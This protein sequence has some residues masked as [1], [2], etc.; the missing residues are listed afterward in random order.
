MIGAHFVKSLFL[1]VL[2][3]LAPLHYIYLDEAGSSAREPVTV[4]VGILVHAD[5][6][7]RV[8]KDA[9]DHALESVPSR[10][11]D[12]F[13]FHAKSI[14][15]DKKYRVEW[16]QEQRLSL[17][18]SVM[19]IPRRL[20]LPIAIGACKRTPEMD[21]INGI[22]AEIHDYIA[23]FGNCITMADRLIS[24]SMPDSEV[25]TL[26]AENCDSVKNH[27]KTSLK[28]LRFGV[29]AGYEIPVIPT[30]SERIT[31]VIK[32]NTA[33]KVSK[34][35]D[36]VHFAEKDEAPLLQIADAC[37]FGIRRFLRRLC[38]LQHQGRALARPALPGVLNLGLPALIWRVGA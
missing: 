29:G 17:L 37:A 26:V 31:G 22:S 23:A 12:G 35:V 3:R 11:A 2:E 30:R 18:I 14:W 24:A 34:I 15:G 27:L 21:G 1:E 7:W 5:S 20:N 36:T 8:A 10:Y 4:V 32:Q 33:L 19:S 28:V 38:T 16:S 13:H 9:L 6:M 25:V